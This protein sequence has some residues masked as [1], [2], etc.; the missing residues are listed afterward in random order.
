MPDFAYNKSI[1][2]I[3][4]DWHDI[5][6]SSIE[7]SDELAKYF[8]VDKKKIQKVAK[9]YPMRINP[10]YLSL[11]IKAGD[12]I[13]RQAVPDQMEIE[14]SFEID[15]PL[16]E[17]SQS[18][19]PNLIHR[20]PDRVL[21]M[22]SSQ[23]AV[24]CRFCMRKRKVGAPF[25]VTDETVREGINYIKKTKSIREV[26]V[27]GGDPLL[28]EDDDLNNLLTKLREISHVEI[29]RIHTRVPCTLPQR[30]TKNLAKILKRFHPLFINIHFNHPDEITC[31]A[32]RACA[33]LADAGIPLGC[34]TVLLKGINNNPR[35]M[36]LLMQKL[37]K[38]RVRPYYI[39]HADPVKG[40]A[41]FRTSIN[42]GLKIMAALRGYVSG[43]C[44]PHYMIDLP[45]GGGK[46]PLL[47]EY[48]KDVIDG[49]LKIKNYKGE[50][51]EYPLNF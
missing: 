43:M 6:S 30:I 5:L 11:M 26:L 27:S 9:R 20:Y 49:K 51:F 48:V 41:H 33:E 23:C 36:K 35:V 14:N 10:Y 16:A 31:Q 28:L 18:P 3:P 45:G 21:F 37:L 40:T 44:V 34:Q 4:P 12:P 13:W 17:E 47:P 25:A 50:F 24:Y 29:I 7:T 1:K 32:S 42:D 8:H 2:N 39:F 38:I 15:D 22:V 46:I 19:V